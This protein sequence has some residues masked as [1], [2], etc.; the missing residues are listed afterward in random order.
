[1]ARGP[2]KGPSKKELIRI[3]RQMMTDLSYAE[4]YIDGM[5]K[6]SEYLKG[7]M[8]SYTEELPKL[9]DEEGG[10]DELNKGG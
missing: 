5:G 9:L 8:L 3:I 1:M 7:Q 10:K 6:R 4:G 2:I